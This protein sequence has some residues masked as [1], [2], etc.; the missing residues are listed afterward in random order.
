MT[1][2]AA[3]PA[4]SAAVIL[5]AGLGSRLRPLTDHTPKPLVRVHGVP[6][7]Y[8]T[9][10]ALAACGVRHCTIVVGY[11]KERLKQACGETF[12]GMAISYVESSVFERTGSAHS[13]W[14]AREVLLGGD[15]LLLEGDV[16]FEPAVIERLLAEPSG[17]AAAVAPFDA[18]MSG[19]AVTLNEAGGIAAVLMNQGPPAGDEPLF[20]TLNLYRFTAGTLRRRVVP[21]LDEVVR[22]GPPM[23]YVEQVLGRLVEEGRPVL[24]AVNCGDLRWFE[25]D[26][27]ADL[28]VAESIFGPAAPSR[29]QMGMTGR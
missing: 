9:L 28:R 23:A 14:L 4:P 5:A 16:L 13:L 7:L 6:I 2:T 27:Q 25:I 24:T 11:C 8:N 1:V 15:V 29:A 20:K 18:A 12:D 26:S 10:A 19:T 17:E 22:S 21:V 3:S